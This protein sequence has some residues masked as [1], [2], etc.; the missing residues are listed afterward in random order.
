M[1]LPCSIVK[2][3]IPNYVDECINDEA[4]ELVQE[5][6]KECEACHKL[7]EDMKQPYKHE[8]SKEIDYLKKV[9]QRNQKRIILAVFITI[10]LLISATIIKKYVIGHQDDQVILKDVQLIDHELT[11]TVDMKNNDESLIDYNITQTDDGKQKLVFQSVNSS[12][13]HQKNDV[14]IVLPIQ[15]I[16][17]YLRIGEDVVDK[18]GKIYDKAV[19]QLVD[20][21]VSYVGDASAVARLFHIMNF[22][23]FGNY[24]FS[25]STDKEPYAIDLHYEKDLTDFDIALI[26]RNSKAVLASIDNCHDICIYTK[27]VNVATIHQEEKILDYQQMQMLLS[28]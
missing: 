1:K 25:L 16:H 22:S 12:F 24:Q 11:I 26:K 8:E 13:L 21:H 10:L 6:L 27:G 19:T 4:R 14:K 20:H 7:Y 17:S 2:E 15:D 18:D 3:V 9:K 5:H 28:F 23:Q